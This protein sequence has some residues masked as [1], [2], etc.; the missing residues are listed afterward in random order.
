MIT[1]DAQSQHGVR[2]LPAQRVHGNS[3]EFEFTRYATRVPTGPGH[4]FNGLHEQHGRL[5]SPFGYKCVTR[6]DD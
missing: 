3:R 1:S 6:A 4:E 2:F 5:A